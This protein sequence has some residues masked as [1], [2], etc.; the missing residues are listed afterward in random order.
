M[1][2]FLREVIE[3]GQPA[4]VLIADD[5]Q[6]AGWGLLDDDLDGCLVFMVYVRR[7]RRRE[8]VGTRLLEKAMS[9]ADKQ[10]KRLQVVVHD[11]PS[12]KF[13]SRHRGLKK[14]YWTWR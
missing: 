1:Y 11:E 12:E 13:Y 9:I 2:G 6:V 3:E 5:G 4:K 10:G 14:E 8:G 7:A